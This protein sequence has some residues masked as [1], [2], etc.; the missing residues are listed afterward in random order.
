MLKEGGNTIKVIISIVICNPLMK[1]VLFFIS[2]FHLKGL[3]EGILHLTAMVTRYD[4]WIEDYRHT[5]LLK[6]I[7]IPPFCPFEV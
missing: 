3:L 5:E 1:M 7:L 2:I 4:N 6:S